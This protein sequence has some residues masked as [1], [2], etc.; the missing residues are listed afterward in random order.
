MNTFGHRLRFTSWGESHGVA[1]GGVLD[2]LPAGIA[3]DM[4]Q[5]QQMV[6][7]RAPGRSALTS[8]R[9]EADEV[10]ILS[11]IYEGR[12]L[13]APIAFVVANA[14]KRSQDYDMFKDVYRPGHADYTYTQKYGYRDHRGGGRSSARETLSRVVA[15][16]LVIQWLKQEGIEITAYASQIGRVQLSRQYSWCELSQARGA[17]LRCPDLITEDL[18]QQEIANALAEGDSV[19][20]VITCIAHGVPS[21]L[22]EP[23]YHKIEAQLASAMLSINAVRGF[24]LGGGFA[25]SGMRG[26]QV[27]DQMGLSEAG[28]L[29][30]M[31]NHAGGALGGITTGEDLVMRIAF[32]PTPT[33]GLPQST[34][35]ANG[36][37]IELKARGRHDPCVVPRALPVVEAMCALVLGDLLLLARSHAH[38]A[39]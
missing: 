35:T 2:G 13:G 31:S 22:G 17:L 25:L 21:G 6:A 3:I 34:V 15:G 36:D 33:I 37:V 4:E 27:N 11:G 32:K 39:R 26:S 24:E 38:F 28:E 5:I 14:D 12:T 29:M 10:Q 30:F 19:G 18:M 8:P 20:G 16:A 1:I 9:T 23:I 7:R